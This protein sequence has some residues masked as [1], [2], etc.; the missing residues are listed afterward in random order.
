MSHENGV[1]QLNDA[2]LLA[3]LDGAL[4]E[5]QARAVEQTP[6][7]QQRLRELAEQERQLTSGLYRAICPEPLELGEY[8]LQRLPVER[9]E[10]IDNHLEA[11][12][13][14][15]E[16][17]AAIGRYL[18]A[19]S[20]D[21]EIGVLEQVRILIARLVSGGGQRGRGGEEGAPGF[22]MPALVGVRGDDEEP[23][24]YD[25]SAVQV[26][27]EVQEDGGRPGRKTILGL[28]LGEAND[29]WHARLWQEGE[30]V[31][32]SAVDDLGNFV[33]SDLEPGSYDLIIGGST[34]E[35]HIQDLSV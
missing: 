7:S 23:L 28:I 25:A 16:E 4:D 9:R 33:L 30:R 35:V 31:A 18:E 11:C 34:L 13:H 27:L 10:V 3:Y 15:A 17:V 24:L 1:P 5:E 20:S 21:L 12:P 6:G 14:C 32:E 29:D 26:S 22:G 19:I 2:Q 8:A